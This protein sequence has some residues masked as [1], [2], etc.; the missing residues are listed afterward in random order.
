MYKGGKFPGFLKLLV[1][2]I[3]VLVFNTEYTNQNKEKNY[4]E[5]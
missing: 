3:K 2:F 4:Y 5:I 1:Y